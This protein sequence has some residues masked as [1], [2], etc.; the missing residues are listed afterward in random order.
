[1][2]TGR[3]A[4][5]RWA[6]AAD[7]LTVLLSAVAVV[8]AFTGGERLTVFGVR[9]SI[10]SWVRPAGWALLAT[11][12]RHKFLPQPSLYTLLLAPRV[13]RHETLAAVVPAVIVSRAAVLLVGLLAVYVFGFPP[14]QG[15][16][17]PVD[18]VATL[19][20]RWDTGWYLG[21]VRN[22]YRPSG[23][24][25]A[26]QNI[27][28][29]PLYP[30]LTRAVG[31]ILGERWLLAGLL[32]SL[33]AFAGGLAYLFRIGKL[34]CR[35]AD[36][37]RLAVALVAAYPFAVFFSAVYTESLFLLCA[38]GAFFHAL[39]RQPVAA[40]AW[41]LGAGLTRPNGV[42]LAAPLAAF[43]AAR[44]W[45]RLGGTWSGGS[46]PGAEGAGPEATGA[47][48]RWGDL[49]MVAAPVAGLCLYAAYIWGLTGDPLA[50]MKAQAGWGRAYEGL[51]GLVPDPFLRRGLFGAFR[52]STPGT[53][54][55]LAALFALC[56][57]V[58][59]TRRHGLAFGLFV[60]LNVLVP[61]ATG[62][63][64]SLGRFTAVLFPMFLYL[65]DAVPPRHQPYW[66]AAFAMGQAL[67]ASMF[68][69][70]RE[71]Y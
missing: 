29:F 5:P 51:A 62:G 40:A 47:G 53:L 12:L 37:P 44:A 36:G 20:H 61:M 26:Q 46:W 2:R 30:L 7:A 38:A 16:I 60:A 49:L 13:P 25:F 21:I 23:E 63:P 45:P 14:G 41:A 71:L 50:W 19:L 58:P 55:S 9:V 70:W 27:A 69:T 64:T 52:F 57:A 48:W 17:A 8:I 18:E 15:P 56:L 11:A 3:E 68:F 35:T 1:M 22:G 33:A 39:R 34:V 67:V 31:E 24:A 28:F 54:N 43:V 59:V 65:A 6:R 42:L 66:I 4:L 32:V 10:T